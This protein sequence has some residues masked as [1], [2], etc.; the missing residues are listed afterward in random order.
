MFDNELDMRA[1][2]NELWK[3]AIDDSYGISEK[4]FNDFSNTVDD[5]LSKLKPSQF[6]EFINLAK[7]EFG[8]VP[9]EKRT[10]W[11]WE[12]SKEELDGMGMGE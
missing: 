3:H 9:A 8:Y 2:M 12:Y 6:E 10:P 4:A 11:E 1:R 5:E 7:T